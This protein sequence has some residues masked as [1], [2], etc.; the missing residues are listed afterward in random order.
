MFM[1]LTAEEHKD[2]IMDTMK[3][4]FKNIITQMSIL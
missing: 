2:D 3:I 4:W 1:H